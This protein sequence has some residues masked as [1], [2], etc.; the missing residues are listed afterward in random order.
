MNTCRERRR[1]AGKQCVEITGLSLPE[2]Y[3]LLGKGAL[4]GE[5]KP[6]RRDAG[7]PGKAVKVRK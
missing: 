1:L 4:A 5:A 3:M 7:A 6:G 2:K